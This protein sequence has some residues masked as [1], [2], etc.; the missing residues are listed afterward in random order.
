MVESVFGVCRIVVDRD[1]VV[2]KID[3]RLSG[4]FIEHLGRVVYTGIYEPLIQAPTELGS[5]RT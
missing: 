4:S 3:P 5:G 2:A 1:F